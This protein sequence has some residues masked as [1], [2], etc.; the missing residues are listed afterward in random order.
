MLRITKTFRGVLHFFRAF[1]T[2]T[3]QVLAAVVFVDSKIF[4]VAVLCA[5]VDGNNI[6]EVP[7]H[8]EYKLIIDSSFKNEL[9]QLPYTAPQYCL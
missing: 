5:N 1:V 3:W 6:D 4:F 9:M 8:L 7:I 2:E